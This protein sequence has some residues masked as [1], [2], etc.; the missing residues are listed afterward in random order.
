VRESE[1]VV[2]LRQSEWVGYKDW[3]AERN[4]SE[5]AASGC[6]LA[7][8]AFVDPVGAKGREER[9]GRRRTKGELESVTCHTNG[10][11]YI[12]ASRTGVYSN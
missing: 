3:P 1:N 7:A 11:R 10:V 6:G 4:E 8:L 5:R 12:G 9:R 2:R